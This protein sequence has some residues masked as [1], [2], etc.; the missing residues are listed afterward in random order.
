MFSSG[1]AQSSWRNWTLGEMRR[2]S[3]LTRPQAIRWLAELGLGLRARREMRHR[4]GEAR[5]RRLQ[6]RRIQAVPI[7]FK[8][9]LGD[10]VYRAP[11]AWLFGRRNCYL[12]NEAQKAE[13][14]VIFKTTLTQLTSCATL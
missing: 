14:L 2:P 12:V 11:N 6:I 1:A 7:A 9:V 3:R 13:I 4:L 5:V 8:T 10:Y